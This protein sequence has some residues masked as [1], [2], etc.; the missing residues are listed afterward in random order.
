[1][2]TGRTPSY[3]NQLGYDKDEFTIDGFL[4]NNV[5][6]ATVHLAT[7]TDTYL[8]G[9][10]AL[11]F[12]EGPPFASTPA[13]VGGTARDGETLTADPGVWQ[14]STPITFTYQWRRCDANG[15]NCVDIAGATGQ[16]YALGTADV[17]ST[18]RVVV[19]A[20]N[21]AGS[22]TSTST[23]TGRVAA[24]PPVNTA[25]PS[26]SGTT[27][28][29]ET[30]TAD[31]GT[32]TGTPNI[33]YAYQWRRCDTAGANCADI[34]G[35]TATTYK[36]TPA[37][38]G[39]T[40]RV[41]VTATNTAGST[42][43]TSGAAGRVDP[44]APANT[45]A[46]TVGGTARDG[47]TLTVD[48]GTWTGTPTITYALQWRR[49]DSSGG[50]CADIAG[51]TG[52]TYKLTSADAGSTVRVVVTATNAAGSATA[53]TAATARVAA[54]PPVNTVAPTISGTT[55]DGGTL[56]VDRGTWT[57][58]PNIT[59]A[60]QWRRCDTTGANCTDISGATSTTYT[61]TSADVAATIRA[62]VTATNSAGTAAAT[63][64]QTARVDAV[65]PA[66]TTLPSISGT[67]R[68][69]QTLTADHG[70]VDRHAEHHVRLPVA[71]LR[72]ERRELRRHQRRHDRDVHARERR[73]RHDDARGRHRDQHRRIGRR[74]VGRGGQ[75]RP[76]A[77]GQHR[78][79]D[80]HRH[81]PRR[82][83]ADR[84]PRHVDRHADDQLH[85]PVAALRRQRVGLQ[86]TS[87]ARPARRTSSRAPTSPTRSASSSRRRTPP[88]TRARPPPRAT[89]SPRPR[90]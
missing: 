55:R 66:N 3:V 86:P 75:G 78:R 5:S 20:T 74:D 16:S 33:T 90:R 61:L 24:T 38:V 47:E 84:Q 43:A 6:S 25:S 58:T 19:T 44:V 68:D 49:C 2:T 42:S 52:T 53:T 30:L 17:G 37:D 62:V 79:A 54:T 15:A 81:H 60:Y 51:A 39:T 41:I 4:G 69:G 72:R 28:D 46:P 80:D 29:G 87:A 45:V 14:G 21:A 57:G 83:D 18:V 8:P 11:A 32:W 63:T 48:R 70:H 13:S 88:A 40:T 76:D 10:M 65:A 73:R 82:P 31:R 22:T 89:R 71:P 26:I 35:A 77:A 56:T 59:Y 7:A 34:A 85:V 9:V 27:R 36:L 23:Q 12:D 1:M 64:T 67:T 50:N